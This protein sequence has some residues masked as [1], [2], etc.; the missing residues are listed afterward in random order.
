MKKILKNFNSKNLS[1]KNTH[2]IETFAKH[3]GLIYGISLSLSVNYGPY[4]KQNR[5]D[6]LKLQKSTFLIL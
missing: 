5:F 1:N 6:A 2:S 4:H 3:N